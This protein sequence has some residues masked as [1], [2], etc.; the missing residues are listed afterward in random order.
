METFPG[1]SARAVRSRLSALRGR[2]LLVALGYPGAALVA[3]ALW[4]I[5]GG[6]GLTASLPTVVALIAL[7]ALS[8]RIEMVVSPRAQVSVAAGFVATAALAG[9]PLAG[10]L[11]G[12]STEASDRGCRRAEALR[13][14]GCLRARRLRDR[15]PRHAAHASRQRRYGTRGCSRRLGHWP[16]GQLA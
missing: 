13:L 8:E 2:G 12:A 4:S 1:I 10:A 15:S 6:R 16:G 7:A 5:S 9:G 14:V 11:A 3:V